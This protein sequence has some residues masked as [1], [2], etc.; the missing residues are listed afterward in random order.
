MSFIDGRNEMKKLLAIFGLAAL[1]YSCDERGLDTINTPGRTQI[2]LVARTVTT[3]DRAEPIAPLYDDS[4]GKWDMTVI[5]TKWDF[6]QVDSGVLRTKFSYYVAVD[7]ECFGI[8]DVESKRKIYEQ[9]YVPAN[10]SA[11]LEMRKLLEH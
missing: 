6:S 7:Y 4:L 10:D 11:A 9:I 3:I 5:G 8:C 2:D 1:A